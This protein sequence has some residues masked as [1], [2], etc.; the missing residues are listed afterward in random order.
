MGTKEMKLALG[1]REAASALSI[2]VESL[3]RL[4]KRGLVHP[5]RA[6]RRPIF[7]VAELERFLKDSM[8][9]TTF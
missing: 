6:T 2:S 5:C 8:T 3:H 9:N 7:S 4:E 1:R